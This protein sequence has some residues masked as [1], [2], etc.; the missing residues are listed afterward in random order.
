MAKK[1]IQAPNAPMVFP[2]GGTPKLVDR[3]A[4]RPS[5]TRGGPF[6]NETAVLRWEAVKQAG[7]PRK[8]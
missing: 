4:P 5:E 8:R 6:A 3:S 1:Q 7:A 2:V